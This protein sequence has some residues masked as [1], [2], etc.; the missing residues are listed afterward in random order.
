[1]GAPSIWLQRQCKWV[2]TNLPNGLQ[3]VAA[4]AARTAECF[5]AAPQDAVAPLRNDIAAGTRWQ[6]PPPGPLIQRAASDGSPFTGISGG[7]GLQASASRDIPKPSNPFETFTLQNFDSPEEGPNAAWNRE[8][9]IA[10][11]G[12]VE[13]GGSPE[14]SEEL[15]AWPP[16]LAKGNEGERCDSSPAALDAAAPAH[17]LAAAAIRN[18]FRASSSVRFRRGSLPLMLEGG[19]DPS[20]WSEVCEE[21][22]PDTSPTSAPSHQGAPA[23]NRNPTSGGL[24]GSKSEPPLV[25]TP[26]SRSPGRPPLPQ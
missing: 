26:L 13:S 12:G 2:V 17:P 19:E 14:R 10:L 24:Q 23:V 6:L 4:A 18:R 7:S 5:V 15:W 22:L 20:A 9:E 8:I 25:R 16:P 11:G 3:V 1:M 21:V